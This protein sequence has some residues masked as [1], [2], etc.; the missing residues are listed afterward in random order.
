[1]LKYD[2][3]TMCGSLALQKLVTLLQ[4]L[5]KCKVIPADEKTCLYKRSSLL[6]PVCLC[7]NEC[8]NNYRF[9]L[10]LSDW[11]NGGAPTSFGYEYVERPNCV[12]RINLK[13]ICE[14]LQQKKFQLCLQQFCNNT[15]FHKNKFTR[16]IFDQ[17]LRTN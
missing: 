11:R 8:P 13:L 3:I 2:K 14:I 10:I 7:N 17:S 15:L 4:I 9:F 6:N 12:Q 16:F 5:A 1:L